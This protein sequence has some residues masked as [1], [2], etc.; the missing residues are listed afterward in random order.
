MVR[1]AQIHPLSRRLVHVDFLA[2]RPERG[3]ARDRAAGSDRQGDRRRPTA[4]TCTRACTWCRWREA[5][6]DPDQAGGR[7]LGLDIGDALHVSDLKLADGVRACSTRRKRRVGRRAEGREGREAAAAPVEGAV[8]A[9]GAA[10]PAAGGAA[11][12]SGRGWRLRRRGGKEEKKRRSSRAPLPSGRVG[13]G[14]PMHLVVGLGNPGAQYAGQPPQP[15]V[16]G[17]RRARAARAR[18]AAARKF[19]AEIAEATLAASASCCA[20]RMEFMNVSGQAVARVAGFWKVALGETIVVHDELD[21]PFGR[22]KL[23]A[24]G[25]PAATT[26]CG[27]SSPRWAMPASPACASALAGRRPAAMPADYVLSN[28][29]RAEAA[30]LP[31]LIG[32]AADAVEAIVSDGLTPAMNRFNGKQK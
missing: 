31:E 20:S 17:R 23:G 18:G 2:R 27:R 16:H 22:L 13:R 9:E 6:G 19:G 11:A 10:A 14:S 5:G 30:V 4:A 8:P 15:R 29:S 25:G 7:R 32:A 3:G 28:F 24:G 26:G 21:L 12:G 1:D